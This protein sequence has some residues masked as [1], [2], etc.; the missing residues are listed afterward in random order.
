MSFN[1]FKMFRKIVQDIAD[2]CGKMIAAG[3]ADTVNSRSED[4]HTH[5]HKKS[6]KSHKH[7]RVSSTPKDSNQASHS[8]TIQAKV[9]DKPAKPDKPDKAEK[10]AQADKDLPKPQKV[11][12]H[13]K[14]STVFFQ[15]CNSMYHLKHLVAVDTQI[16]Y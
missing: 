5:T 15:K 16:K 8:H 14:V 10:P 4:T 12:T 6:R 13:T 1:V 11:D 2:I 9:A 7:G 3:A